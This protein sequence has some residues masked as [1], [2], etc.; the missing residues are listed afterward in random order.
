MTTSGLN[1]AFSFITIT[2]FFILAVASVLSDNFLPD[3]FPENQGHRIEQQLQ[4]EA[5]LKSAIHHIPADRKAWNR[6]KKNLIGQIIHKTRVLTDQRLPLNLKETGSVKMNSY[7]IKNISFQSR[8]GIYATANLYIPDGHGK[9][10]GVIV[11]MGHSSNG[12]FYEKYQAVGVSLALNNYVALCIDP[13]GAGER[14]T[15]QGIFEDHGDENNLGA[16]LMDVGETLMGMQ[17]TDNIRGV[18][19]LSELPFVDAR[20]IGATGSSGGGNQTIWLTAM[21]K[22]IKAAVPVVSAGTYQSFVMGSPCICEVLPDALTF[23]EEAAVLGLAAPRY[24]KLCNHYKDA[25][26]AFQP[27]EMLRSYKN[28]LPVFEMTGSKNNIS[29]QL[30]DL[31]HGYFPEDIKTML[32]WFNFHLK[33]MDSV[34]EVKDTPQQTL[35]YQQLMV[36]PK[37]QR[38][39][40]I[41]ST[42]EYC[43]KKGNE[44]RSVFLSHN[45]FNVSEKRKALKEILRAQDENNL[46]RT[47]EYPPVNGWKRIAL[48]TKNDQLIPVLL[49]EPSGNSKDWVIVSHP[50]GKGKIPQD[51]IERMIRSG[52]GIAVV[53]LSGT[54]ELSS[55]TLHSDDSTGRLRTL[56]KSNLL[57]GKTVMGEWVR[58]LQIVTRFMHSKYGSALVSIYGYK[59]AGLAGLYLAALDGKITRVTLN[60]APASYLF[61]N[62]EGIEFFS[63]AIHVP[64]LLNWGDISLAAA[65]TGKNIT[66]VH[67]VTMSGNSISGDKLDSCKNEFIQIRNACRLPGETEFK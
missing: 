49:R 22:R 53:D 61:D 27:G 31:P 15:S 57:L 44:L 21:D 10:P 56:S 63:T 48:E 7:T 58:E 42:A 37:E 12:R 60:S 47:N 59:E 40:G 1:K 36:Y 9:F 29:Y 51:L 17:I 11:M 45:T 67:P 35:P 39:A 25:N 8:P 32:Q 14:T 23:T 38:D 16:A 26:A 24:L 20:N 62:R 4:E 54:G 65:L 2:C 3:V 13:W 18:D 66:F 34:S 55:N 30:Y 52:S 50:D 5:A 6:L 64:G 19:V 33:N 43:R 28:V 46:K 41:M